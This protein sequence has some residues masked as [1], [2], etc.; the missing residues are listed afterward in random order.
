VQFKAKSRAAVKL[1]CTKQHQYGTLG[2]PDNRCVTYI[3]NTHTHTQPFYG[4]VNFLQDNLGELVPEETPV[5]TAA[6]NKCATY[7]NLLSYLILRA[8]VHI[9]HTNF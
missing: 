1:K 6:D 3:T 9:N 2:F 7:I 5:S 4:S 8:T